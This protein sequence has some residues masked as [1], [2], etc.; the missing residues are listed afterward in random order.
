M[1]ILKTLNLNI[2]MIQTRIKLHIPKETVTQQVKITTNLYVINFEKNAMQKL[3]Q[4]VQHNSNNPKNTF[5]HKRIYEKVH[6][7][8]APKD[9]AFRN[10]VNKFAQSE[11]PKFLLVFKST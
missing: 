4:N 5:L 2:K 11:I 3:A 8:H 6:T 1:D 9:Y 7:K 10:L